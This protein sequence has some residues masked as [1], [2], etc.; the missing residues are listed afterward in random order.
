MDQD[1]AS[2][3]LWKGDCG[4]T[5]NKALDKSSAIRDLHPFV[6]NKGIIRIKTR[7]DNVEA[8]ENVKCLVLLPAD[9]RCTHL[10]VDSEHR[11]LLHSGV[12]VALTELREK[13]WIVRGR[14]CVKGD[15]PVRR[16]N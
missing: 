12:G 9:H 16:F 4:L 8:S 7:L 11:R 3:K 14:L 13:F 6:D 5:S 10:I 15:W 2:T 1:F